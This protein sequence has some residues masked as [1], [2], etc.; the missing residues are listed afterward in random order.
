MAVLHQVRKGRDA[1]HRPYRKRYA[2]NLIHHK[3][4][5]ADRKIQLELAPPTEKECKEEEKNTDNV[6][7]VAN[8]DIR[9]KHQ[10]FSKVKN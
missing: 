9:N 10:H 7:V 1:Y 6:E 2:C 8:A 4:Q 3:G 5:R